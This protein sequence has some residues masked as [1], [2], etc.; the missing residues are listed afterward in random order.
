MKRVY[1]PRSVA[2]TSMPYIVNR[3]IK[4]F[5]KDIEVYILARE[6]NLQVMLKVNGVNGVYVVNTPSFNNS[7]KVLGLDNIFADDIV[8]I[9]VT[10]LSKSQSYSNVIKFIRNIFK[11]NEIYLCSFDDS[12]LVALK[13]LNMLNQFAQNFYLGLSYFFAIFFFAVFMIFVALKIIIS[14]K[15]KG[16]YLQES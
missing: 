3:I 7:S 1:V 16:D 11:K 4:E 2:E 10:N 5:G 14:K 6:E 9:P 8:V 13:S 15:N 12:K